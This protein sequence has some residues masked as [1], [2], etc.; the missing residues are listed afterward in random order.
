MA[1]EGLKRKAVKG[2]AW[3]IGQTLAN[4]SVAFVI[5]IIIARLVM[6]S[7]FGLIAMLGVFTAVAGC[8]IDS[9]LAT[10][11]IRKT[12]RTDVDCST[13]FYFNIVVAVVMYIVL[14]ICAPTISRF[15][16]M[17]ELTAILRVS[18]L[19]LIIGG[20]A[21][22]QRMLYRANIDF[23][24]PA[25]CSFVSSIISGFIAIVMAYND[26]QV[27]A[28]VAQSIIGT[29]LC[30]IFMWVASKWRP[31]W[32]FS[33]A[34]LKESL[35][36]GSKLL[37]SG[38][39]D[40]I[41]NQI[42]PITIGKFFSASQLAFFNRAHNFSSLMSQTPTSM[43]NSVAYPTLC[44][45]QESD[46]TLAMGYRRM[47]RLASFVVFP[48][49]LGLGAV[50]YPLVNV[51][52]TAKWIYA[53]SLLEIVVFS[54]MWYPIHALNLNLLQVKGRSDLFLK[55][56]V[57]KKIMG[58]AAM[59]VT[60]PLGV[61]A[62]CYGG[63]VTSVLCLFINT[64]YTK[65]LIGLG[66]MKQARDFSKSLV[67]ALAMF[68]VCRVIIYFLGNGMVSLATAVVAGAAIYLSIAVIFKFDEV[69]EVRNLLKR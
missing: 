63:V 44:K 66:L 42:Y 8:F 35:G 58:V 65:K 49:T 29:G 64:H 24:T 50:A 19:G 67:A 37:A 52:L 3:N 14:F 38:L 5:S 7:Q 21:S 30:T 10:A 11:L 23:K 15:Y 13:M 53:A 43:L 61:K 16:D 27:W 47:I 57:I 20:T 55:L 34:S 31:V 56:E 18:A 45:L 33:F 39:L 17:P 22:V 68:A 2:A 59:C 41:Y 48:M 51:M 6:P 32:R 1:E 69:T 25:I 36:F 62:M 9:G 26:W 12:D 40:T 4:Q 46:E 54:A 28:L 60:I